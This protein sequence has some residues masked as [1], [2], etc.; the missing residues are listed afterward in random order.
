MAKGYTTRKLEVWSV[1]AHQGEQS[2]SAVDYEE[3]FTAISAAS[4]E[5]RVQSGAERL[6]ALSRLEIDAS[7][8][9]ITAYEGT[10]G[11]NPLIFN[12]LS[13]EE[14]VQHLAQGEVVATKTHA[15]VNLSSRTAIVEYNHQG[16]KASDIASVL[17]STG[18]VLG[19]EGLK[20]E[21]N[22]L[23]SE[24]FIGEVERFERIR[25]ATARLVR[26]NLGW[27]D[28]EDE[29]TE[30]AE[31]SDAQAV[32]VEFTAPRGESLSQTAGVV[33]FIRRLATTP[34]SP[35]KR[36]SLTGRRQ[37]EDEETT[38]STTNHVE[39]QR[40]NVRLDPDGHV[41]DADIQQ[42]PADFDVARSADEV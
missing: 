12:T 11:L 31:D 36:A 24:S 9:W 13:S 15:L 37:G 40:I 7:Q 35:L 29:L 1:H 20:V 19:W 22:P 16:A 33:P 21:L 3:L 41:S 5:Q 32:N 8:I 30:A 27:S 23:V 39:H 34:L 26:P 10:R 14:R 6:V 25:E 28:W 18:R 38:V 4:P 17:G 2:P 42:H